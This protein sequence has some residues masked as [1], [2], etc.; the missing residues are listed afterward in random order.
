M[1]QKFRKLTFVHVSK[2]MPSHMGHFESDF[3]AII[4]G[5]YSQL[6]GG[7]DIDSYALYQLEDGKIMGEFKWSRRKAHRSLFDLSGVEIRDVEMGQLLSRA[8]IC[9]EDE[10]DSLNEEVAA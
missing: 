4:E 1:K 10:A 9:E 7:K 6:H 8:K 2:D 3:D 5:T